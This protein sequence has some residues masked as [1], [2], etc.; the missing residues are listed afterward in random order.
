MPQRRGDFIRHQDV[1]QFQRGT[2]IA[3]AGT[4]SQEQLSGL[5]RH[6]IPNLD[7]KMFKMFILD[8]DL[9]AA[10]APLTGATQATA[11]VLIPDPDEQATDTVPQDLVESDQQIE[12]VNRDP[13]TSGDAET[14][15]MAIWL[16]NEWLVLSLGC[17]AISVSAA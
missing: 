15:G 4:G 17:S 8:D 6:A 9:T 14:L 10:T 7:R 13:D 2:R 3:N 16:N 11:T 5:G 12:V 1:N